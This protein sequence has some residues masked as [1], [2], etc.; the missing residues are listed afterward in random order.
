MVGDLGLL[1][2]AVLAASVTRDVDVVPADDGV[3][4]EQHAPTLVTWQQVDGALAGA[5]PL[6]EAGV[7]RLADYLMV[8]AHL[9]GLDDD[10]DRD[11]RPFAAPLHAPW[12][13]GPGFTRLRLPGSAIEV[14][15]GMVGP[16]P[17]DP[18][19]VVPVARGA[20]SASGRPWAEA[21]WWQ[22]AVDTLER[23]G[24]L[25]ATRLDRDPDLP[26]RPLG[27]ADVVTLLASSVLRGALVAG[28]QGLRAVA[29]P[30]RRCAWLDPSRVDP[31]FCRIAYQLIDSSESAFDRP[32]LI[33]A[34]EVVLAGS[35]PG[36]LR[37]AL[38]DDV[39]DP[40]PTEGRRW[41]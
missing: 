36:V 16:D 37:T 41:V 39:V 9:S 3:V 28:H 32:L 12:H 21:T 13:P 27:D 30:S 14:G 11:V 2:R 10:E 33:S 15:M 31:A 35:G 29:A 38:T 40:G 5:A 20:L 8:R 4:L 18:E 1:R 6:S 24:T 19:R 26:L 34:H 7:D 25:A 17:L 22:R 23:L